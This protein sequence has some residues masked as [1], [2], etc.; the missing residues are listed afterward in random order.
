MPRRYWLSWDP[1]GMPLLID[2]SSPILVAPCLPYPACHTLPARGLP[3]T[4]TT[5]HGDL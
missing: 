2:P 1:T 4:T 3:T 5:N